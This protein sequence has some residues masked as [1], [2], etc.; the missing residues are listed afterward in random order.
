MSKLKIFTLF[1]SLV[2]FMMGANG[3]SKNQI[4]ELNIK[5]TR[6][7]EYDYTSAKESKRKVSFEKFN[8]HGQITE[9]IDYDKAGKQKERI[10]F[11]YNEDGDLVE[12][13]YFDNSNKLLKY[14][15]YT[16][17]NRLRQ[18]KEKYNAKKKLVWRK[19]YEYDM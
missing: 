6:V 2:T 4:L 15:T 10:T 9:F 16:Y 13:R 14:Y 5:S 1:F 3:Q 19:V 17:Q 12:E 18:T 7:I 11:S 8:S